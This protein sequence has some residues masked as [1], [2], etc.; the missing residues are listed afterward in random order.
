[1]SGELLTPIDRHFYRH[2]P[3]GKI[4]VHRLLDFL[5][6]RIWQFPMFKSSDVLY[7]NLLILISFCVLLAWGRAYVSTAYL[8]FE[9]QLRIWHVLF[10][11]FVGENTV[12]I[13][14]SNLTL[15]VPLISRVFCLPFWTSIRVPS[16]LYKVAIILVSHH[17]L[18][19]S[20]PIWYSKY[21]M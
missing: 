16:V 10:W 17:S 11:L 1:M 8:S 4:I 19:T 7:W 14:R 3:H 13:I 15:Q 20:L 6:R 21:F 2:F 18:I 12:L 9:I 5:I